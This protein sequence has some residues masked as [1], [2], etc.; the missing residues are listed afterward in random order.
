LSELGDEYS[1][2]Y[3]GFEDP[4]LSFTCRCGGVAETTVQQLLIPVF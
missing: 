4:I 1:L 3:E 2:E